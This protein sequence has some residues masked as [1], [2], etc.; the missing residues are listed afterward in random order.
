MATE[1]SPSNAKAKHK[2]STHHE[3]MENGELRFRLLHVDGSAYV[4]TEAASS[5]GWQKSHVHQT[6]METYIVQH[7]WMALAELINGQRVVRIFERGGIVTTRP[8]VTHNVYL[9]NDTVIHTVK[10][11]HVSGADRER[12]PNGQAFD[13]I[14]KELDSEDEIRAAAIRAS[15]MTSYGEEYR[16]FDNLIWQVPAWATAIFAL[17]IQ[18]VLEMLGR[19]DLAQNHWQWLAVLILFLASCVACFSL[20]LARF[21]IHQRAFKGFSDTPRWKSASTW[22]QSLLALEISALVG[23]ALVFIG[24]H[25]PWAVGLSTGLGLAAIGVTEFA[26]RRAKLP[27]R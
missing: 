27:G 24:V 9:P 13:L 15:N 16:H 17:S 10:H 26:I 14:T 18:S 21:R 1:I 25:L 8:G 3:C 11:G 12:G 7:G 19:S 5:G 22:T 23:I 4:R 20:V 6:V 2:I